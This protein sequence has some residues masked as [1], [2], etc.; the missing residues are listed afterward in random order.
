MPHTA[1]I[2][3]STN[4]PHLQVPKLNHVINY[5][6]R[7]D[8]G[9]G[10]KGRSRVPYPP[11]CWCWQMLQNSQPK[12]CSWTGSFSR[13]LIPPSEKPRVKPTISELQN[14]FP[15]PAAVCEGHFKHKR[16]VCQGKE[17]PML[18]QKSL[19]TCIQQAWFEP[20]P[21]ETPPA[22]EPVSPLNVSLRR[23]SLDR[24]GE[25]VNPSVSTRV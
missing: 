1:Q 14:D 23:C 13:S 25:R 3:L 17:Y 10:V 18:L 9:E 7:L 11:A 2:S 12:G 6:A 24:T 22:H 4:R 15:C 16:V 19:V 8:A 20:Q 5:V 21:W